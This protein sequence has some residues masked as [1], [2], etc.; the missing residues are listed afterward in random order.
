MAFIKKN[1]V[2]IFP[3]L[4]LRK[5]TN[6]GK[7]QRIVKSF[8]IYFLIKLHQAIADLKK[9]SKGFNCFISINFFTFSINYELFF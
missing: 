3:R 7:E 5:R 9:K 8:L 4:V 1:T 2:N 6:H